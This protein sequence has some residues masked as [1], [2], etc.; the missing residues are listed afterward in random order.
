MSEMDVETED[1]IDPPAPPELAPETPEADALDQAREV[2]DD[3]DDLY[4]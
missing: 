2:G 3:D 4:R 1:F